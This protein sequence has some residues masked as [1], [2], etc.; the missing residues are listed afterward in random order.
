MRSSRVAILAVT[1]GSALLAWSTQGVTA[2]GG[3]LSQAS[4][5]TVELHQH[6]HEHDGESEHGHHGGRGGV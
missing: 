1:L 4:T 5:G 3:T 6:D 2:V